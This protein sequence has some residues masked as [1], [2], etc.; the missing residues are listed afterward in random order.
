MSLAKEDIEKFEIKIWQSIA[1]YLDNVDLDFGFY[2]RLSAFEDI[3]KE[4]IFDVS[5]KHCNYSIVYYFVDDD[6]KIAFYK[7]DD[8]INKLFMPINGIDYKVIINEL[9]RSIE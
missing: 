5:A 7:N 3:E 1:N 9:K 2:T 8:F 4:Y 6:V